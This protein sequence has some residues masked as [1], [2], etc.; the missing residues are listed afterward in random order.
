M[1][2]SARITGN[3]TKARQGLQTLVSAIVYIHNWTKIRVC[4]LALKI[5]AFDQDI[6][7]ADL[8]RALRGETKRWHSQREKSLGQGL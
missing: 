1:T 8:I 6:W 4:N 3:S 5:E 7:H 2:P